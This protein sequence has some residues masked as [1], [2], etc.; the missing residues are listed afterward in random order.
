M[1]WMGPKGF[2]WRDRVRLSGC[3]MRKACEKGA[4]TCPGRGE[5]GEE[6][7]SGTSQGGTK[8]H[9]FLQEGHTPRFWGLLLYLAAVFLGINFFF[10]F[11]FM[12]LLDTRASSW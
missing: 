1:H 4:A 7:V 3:K 8:N 6:E 2:S 10:N 11:F 9:H 12:I 5:L